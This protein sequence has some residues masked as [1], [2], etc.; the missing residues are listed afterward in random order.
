MHLIKESQCLL[1]CLVSSVQ[2]ASGVL[3]LGQVGENLGLVDTVS[4]IAEQHEGLSVAGNTLGV[5]AETAV[6]RAQA[7]QTMSYAAA[8]TDLAED[9]EGF[10]AAGQ[11]LFMIA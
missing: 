5:M 8:V 7:V 9:R 1:P 3:A 11:G 4:G 10:L 2:V 6:S